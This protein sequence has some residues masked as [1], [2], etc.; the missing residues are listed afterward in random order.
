M[1]DRTV[2][3]GDLICGL[4][5]WKKVRT[6]TRVRGLADQ[7]SSRS[8]IGSNFPSVLLHNYTCTLQYVLFVEPSTDEPGWW[9]PM[10]GPGGVTKPIFRARAPPGSDIDAFCFNSSAL[11]PFMIL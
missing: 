4:D 8:N 10:R 1:T 9:L 3:L 7:L 11:P 6:L 5:E 2:I